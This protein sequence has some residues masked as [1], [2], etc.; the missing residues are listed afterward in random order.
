MAKLNNSVKQDD[1]AD[2]RTAQ[3]IRMP[4]GKTNFYMMAGCLVLII[5]GFALM[6]GG[7]SADGV[8][9]NPEVFSTRRIVVGP[10]ITFLGFLL[11]AFAIIWKPR[12]LKK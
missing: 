4:F 1:K 3:Y 9:F 8:T 11:M 5:V 7:G 12:S 6:S 10:A 2:D